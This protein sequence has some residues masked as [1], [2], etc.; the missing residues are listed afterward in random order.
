MATHLAGI[1]S[2]LVFGVFFFLIYCSANYPRKCVTVPGQ[3]HYQCE[4]E[5]DA[6]TFE[7]NS[8]GSGGY[9]QLVISHQ[10]SVW[11]PYNCTIHIHT[12]IWARLNA[13][14]QLPQGDT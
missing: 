11:M 3:R 10:R 8:D 5:V 1:H 12:S 13:K 2:S 4:I 7:T 14:L 9:C 6:A